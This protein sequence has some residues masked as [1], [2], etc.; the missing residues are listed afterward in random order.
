MGFERRKSDPVFEESLK[1]VRSENSPKEA[2]P[3][4]PDK[5]SPRGLRDVD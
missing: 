3:R 5:V 4:S 2:E 1:T